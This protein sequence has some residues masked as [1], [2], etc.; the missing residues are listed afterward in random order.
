M[1]IKL[2][3]Q[4]RGFKK[5]LHVESSFIL[6]STSSIFFCLLGT[7]C[8]AFFSH[9]QRQLSSTSASFANA[10]WDSPCSIRYFFILPP[11]VEVSTGK[12]LYP[13]NAII[14]GQ[15]VI[16]GCL[17]RSIQLIIV[18]SSTFKRRAISFCVIFNS[19]CLFL[20][21]SPKLFGFSICCNGIR[22]FSSRSKKGN[23]SMSVRIS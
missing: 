9:L 21:C 4:H 11:R 12:G 23:A 3:S 15:K 14:L 5:S 18:S 7:G 16:C 17:P 10:S 1:V 22:A 19:V 6:F 20:K 2:C 8:L 13:K